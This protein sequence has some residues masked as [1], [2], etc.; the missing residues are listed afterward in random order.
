MASNPGE[1][2]LPRFLGEADLNGKVLRGIGFQGGDFDDTAGVTPFTGAPGT[3][4]GGAQT[5]F[6]STTFYP[7]RMWAASYFGELTGGSTNLVVTPVQHRVDAIGDATATRRLFSTLDLQLFYADDDDEFAA[8]AAAPAISEVSATIDDGIV[9]F[10]ARIHGTDHLGADNLRSAWLTY[11]FGENGPCSC[12]QSIELAPSETDDSIWTAELDILA[13]DPDDLRFIAQAVNGAALVGINDNAGAFHSLASTAAGMP[14]TTT[15]E[16]ATPSS[17]TG[18]YG[19][20]ITVSA[21]LTEKAGHP[22]KA[23]SSRSG[24]VWRSATGPRTRTAS[25]R[26]R[27]R[28]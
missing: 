5:P 17:P 19:S 10:G 6:T 14:A 9:T 26:R 24:S 28:C 11:T 15:L 21:T 12:W 18:A 2:A 23:R 7:A 3:E 22:S 4:F 25:R 8:L 27:S 1:P 13:A 16:L 20:E